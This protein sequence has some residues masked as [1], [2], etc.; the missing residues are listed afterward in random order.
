M[1]DCCCTIPTPQS[2]LDDDNRDVFEEI[3]DDSE[4]FHTIMR[5]ILWS[6]YQYRGIGNCDVDYWVQTMKNRYLQIRVAYLPKFKLL[7]EWL[8]DV[9]GND[10]VDLSEGATNYTMMTEIEDTPDNPQ[11]TSVYLSDRNTVTYNGKTYSGLS[12]ET[13]SRFMD[14]IPDLSQQFADEFQKQFY[15]GL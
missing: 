11:G 14:Y 4:V 13:V 6:F 3:I 12:S 8:T 15:W 5:D 7:D 1:S 9:M 10:P 2:I